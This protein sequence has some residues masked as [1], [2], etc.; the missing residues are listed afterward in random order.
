MDYNQL[1]K[2]YNLLLKENQK[3]IKENKDLRVQLKLPLKQF[4]YFD[5][6]D[7]TNDN[8]IQFCEPKDVYSKSSNS[9]KIN[10]FMSLFRGRID[11]YAKRWQN[12]EGKSGYSPVCLN[13]WEKGICNKPTIKCS[14]CANKKYAELDYNSIDNHLRGKEILGIYPI[15]KDDD[16]YFVAID[17]D[18]EGWE[19]DITVLRDIC[20]KKSIPIAVERSRSGSGAHAWFFFKDKVSASIARKFGSAL[21]TYAMSERHEIKFSS[22]DRLFPNQDSLPKGGLGNLIALPLQYHSRKNN[23]S[24]FIDENFEPYKDQW[25]C[26]SNINKLTEDDIGKYISELCNGSELGDLRLNND[27]ELKPWEMNN[28]KHNLNQ[29]DFPKEVTII[30]SNMLYINKEGF[31]NKVLN[32]IKRLSSFKNP[33][34]YKSQ[35]MRLS[36]YDKPSII[37]LCE[38]TSNYL[39]IPRGCEIELRELFLKYN[40]DVKWIDNTNLGKQIDIKFIGQLREEQEYAFNALAKYDTGVLSATTAFGKTVI[41]A[42]LIAGKFLGEGFDE[43]RLDTLFLAMPVAW[44]GTV[45]QYAGRLHRIYNNKKEVLVY[46]YVDIHIGV[47]ERMYQKRFKGYASISYSVK[48]DCTPLVAGNAIY[49]NNNFLNAFSSD[50]ISSK[51]EVLI[52]SPIMTMKYLIRML[53][54]FNIGLKNGQN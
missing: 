29:K 9:D 39:C 48:S 43:P 30:K 5:R 11:V 21:I 7:I 17:F 54:F 6:A 35:A 20:T 37:S 53:S 10:L 24:V 23:N 34:F 4:N 38:E 19:K 13:E 26:L 44:K 49:N 25:Q 28:L 27:D 16:C 46:D 8:E 41:G 42:N 52:V 47:L 3:L 36:T 32:I 50:I 18:D 31:T 45:Q 14:N 12:R 15:L 2:K 51:S 40:I 22:Y 33:E 1:L